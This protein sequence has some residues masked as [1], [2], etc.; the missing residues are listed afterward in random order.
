MKING[1]LFVQAINF[2]IGYILLR[3]FLFKPVVSL[4][5]QKD[6]DRETVQKNIDLLNEQIALSKEEQEMLWKGLALDIEEKCRSIK[7]NEDSEPIEDSDI[8]SIPNL[9]TV[10]FFKNQPDDINRLRSAVLMTQS[11]P[12]KKVS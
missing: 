4:I 3:Y 9:E 12:S 5:L 7:R 8:K 1:T 11:S 6:Q 10:A 2:G